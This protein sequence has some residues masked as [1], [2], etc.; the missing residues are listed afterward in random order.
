[1]GWGPAPLDDGSGRFFAR[2]V[3]VTI[4]VD[5]EARRKDNFDLKTVRNIRENATTLEFKTADFEEE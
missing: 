3:E 4:T 5:I 1:M 2:A